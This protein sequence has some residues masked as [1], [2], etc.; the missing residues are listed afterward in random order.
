MEEGTEP[1]LPDLGERRDMAVK[2]SFQELEF[3]DAFLFALTMEDEE[4][5]R[6]VLERILEIP[7]HAVKVR[8]ENMLLVNSDQ[9]GIRMDVYADDQAGTVFDVEMQTTDRGNLPKRSR[10][11]QSQMD[12]AQLKPG[13]D[14][15]LLPKSFVIFLLSLIHI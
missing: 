5:C 3:K 2:K 6:E 8:S 13:E 9:R 15:N 10:Y 14:F 4:I 11:Y 1:V 7:V 12:S